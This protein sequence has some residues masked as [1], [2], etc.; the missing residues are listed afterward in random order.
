MPAGPMNSL[1]AEPSLYLRQHAA[2]PVDWYPWGEAALERARTTDTPILLSIGYS[3][4]HWCHVMAH[5]CFENEAIA[6]LMNRLFVCIKVDREE[7]PDLDG[8]YMKAVQGMT[9]RGGW[10]MTV[11]LTPAQ[12][13]FYAG[14]YFPPEERGGLPGFPRILEAVARAYRDQP[15]RVRETSGRVVAFLEQTPIADTSRSDA[16][17]RAAAGDSL[18]GLMD[19]EHGGFGTAPKFPNSVPLIFLMELE[20][21]QPSLARMTALRLALDRMA[22]GGIYD[23]LGGGFHRYAVDRAW[24]VPHFEKM[25]YDQALLVD[26]Y[27]DAWLLLRDDSYRRVAL[28]TLDYV[29]RD[30]SAETGGFF[31]SQDADSDGGEGTFFVWSRA[32]VEAALDA[33]DFEIAS[34]YFDVAERGNFGDTNVLRRASS[35][36]HVARSLGKDVTEARAAIERIRRVL[37]AERGGR[38]PPVTDRKILA[39][40]NGLMIG[41]MARAGRLFERR[42]LVTTARKAADFIRSRMWPAD[43]LLHFWSEGVARGG[44]FVDDYAFFG[45]GCLDLYAATNDPEYFRIAV[46]CAELLTA[47]FEDRESGGFF[48]VAEGEEQTVYRPKHLHDGALPAGTAVATELMARLYA[49]TGVHDFARAAERSLSAWDRSAAANPH[50]GAQLLTVSHR[51]SLGYGAV[52]VA[53]AGLRCDLLDAS[54][55]LDA[56]ELTVLSANPAGAPVAAKAAVAGR[57]TAFVCRANT[58]SAPLH[59]VR[60]LIAAARGV[61][62]A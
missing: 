4:C 45:R 25:L 3:S 47:R 24:H 39:D 59:D 27:T 14:T 40:W 26:L 29:A 15:D 41:A 44:G 10:P 19:P 50:A 16:M 23:Q 38:T 5:E 58:C 21:A 1:A 57:S 52:V 56:P 12:S 60:E 51:D 7:R 33:S 37:L 43:A 13:P 28:E 35:P 48:Y 61:T 18:M 62:P 42:D 9:G 20:R 8:I 31:A 36:D 55:R 11:F 46:S 22:E 6:A 34:L 53:E 54:L 30:L 32:E 2:N 49:L 17:A